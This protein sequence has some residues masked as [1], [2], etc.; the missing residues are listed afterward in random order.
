MINADGDAGRSSMVVAE[1]KTT[2]RAAPAK[3]VV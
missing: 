1:L 2:S 3:P